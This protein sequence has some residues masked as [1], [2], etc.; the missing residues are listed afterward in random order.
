MVDNGTAMA[1]SKSNYA[2]R[3]LFVAVIRK[4]MY[5]EKCARAFHRALDN[6]RTFLYLELKT[7]IISFKYAT[8]QFHHFIIL[9]Q[10]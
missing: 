1:P 9:C 6:T 2:T 7:I 8:S 3:Q 5:G 10:L 4:T